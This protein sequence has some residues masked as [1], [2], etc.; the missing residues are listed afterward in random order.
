[1]YLRKKERYATIQIVTV[2]GETKLSWVSGPEYRPTK[3]VKRNHDIC[4][5]EDYEDQQWMERYQYRIGQLVSNRI[6]GKLLRHIAALIGFD[7][8][9]EEAEAKRG[10]GR[11]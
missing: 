11:W 2:T 4:T 10:N 8:K 9:K 3:Y 1:M 6:G 7:D 5:A